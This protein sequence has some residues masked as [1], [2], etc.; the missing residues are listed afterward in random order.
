[1][2]IYIYLYTCTVVGL[3]A[4]ISEHGRARYVSIRTQTP[5]SEYIC[6]HI[7]TPRPAT[8]EQGTPS[9]YRSTCRGQSAGGC[10]HSACVYMCVCM[11]MCKYVNACLC[12]CDTIFNSQF[13]LMLRFL[14]YSLFIV[15]SEASRL[16]NKLNLVTQ[17]RLSRHRHALLRVRGGIRAFFLFGE[18][19]KETNLHQPCGRGAEMGGF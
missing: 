6:I 12:A 18:I 16:F 4:Y 17:T 13:W 14:Q 10:A 19:L 11:Y 5:S 8:R 2:Y 7:H 1:V 9:K 15:N 3:L